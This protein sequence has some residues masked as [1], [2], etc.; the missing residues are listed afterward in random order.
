MAVCGQYQYSI[1]K[2]KLKQ[3]RRLTIKEYFQKRK[4]KRIER[5]AV[6]EM[7][8]I[9]N[10]TDRIARDY[11]KEKQKEYVRKRMKESRKMAQRFN[12]GTP[13]VDFITY[14]EYKIKRYYG[15]YF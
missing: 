13:P 6:S 15:R 11:E 14:V 4:Q 10:I 7:A 9:D 3:S 8:K 12:K 2:A 1:D 5:K